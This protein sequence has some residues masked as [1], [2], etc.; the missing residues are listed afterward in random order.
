MTTSLY[1]PPLLFDM[2]ARRLA[3]ASM[4]LALIALAMAGIGL[5]ELATSPPVHGPGPAGLNGTNGSAGAQGPP[6]TSGSTGASGLP[7]ANGTDGVNGTSGVNGTDGSNGTNAPVP[8]YGTLNAT[9]VL[10]GNAGNMTLNSTGCYNEGSGLYLCSVSVGF[11]A[12][13]GMCHGQYRYVAGLNYTEPLYLHSK[14]SVMFV[15]SNPT[16]PTARI[17][18]GQSLALGLWFQVLTP[19]G[20]VSTTVDLDIGVGS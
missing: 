7:G 20:V 1:P 6:G 9:F 17:T 13:P 19:S 16:L 14:A 10:T 4:L 11:D 5:T 12:P 2:A 8:T 18:A 15:S 3:F